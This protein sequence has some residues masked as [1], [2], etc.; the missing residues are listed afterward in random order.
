[1]LHGTNVTN[2]VWLIIEVMKSHCDG[3]L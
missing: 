2:Y 1:M 3:L